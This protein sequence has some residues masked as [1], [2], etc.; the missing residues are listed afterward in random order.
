MHLGMKKKQ[1]IAHVF[2]HIF[3]I[4]FAFLMLF[5]IIYA[6]FGSFKSNS[7][8]LVEP[9]RLLPKVWNFNNYIDAWK[10][11]YFPV[12]R[13]LL[14]SLLYTAASVTITLVISSVEG[15][16]FERGEFRGKNLIF[17][18][19]LSTMFI[20]MGGVSIYA[21]FKIYG[22]LN[23]PVS[24]WSLVVLKIF[25][26]P[27]YN[28]FLIRNNIRSLPKELDE[29]AKIDGCGF[30]NIFFRITLPLIKPM[31]VT[32]VI[33]SFQSSWNEYIMPTIFTTTNPKQRTLMVGLMQLKSSG[34]SASNW[35]LMLAG[36]VIA[37]I[38]VIIL[39]IFANKQFVK[40]MMD[41]ALKG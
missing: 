13:L 23:V 24:L 25:S 26:M 4:F 6:F 41:G 32:L 35:S 28:V 27:I 37:L 16:V 2:T 21:T 18:I 14:N 12:P 3:L 19:F 17:S 9:G 31:L 5:P 30:M 7:E 22:F 15:Y 38:P 29:S 20:T 1:Q 39:F 40:G 34:E 10:S 33:L 11:E 8:L 36:S